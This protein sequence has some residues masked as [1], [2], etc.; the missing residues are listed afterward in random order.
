[1]PDCQFS[2]PT[3]NAGIFQKNARFVGRLGSAPRLVVDRANVVT[4]V[5]SHPAPGPPAVTYSTAPNGPR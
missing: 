1:M 5:Y 2:K 3:Y 4:S